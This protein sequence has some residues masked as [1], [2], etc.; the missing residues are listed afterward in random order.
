MYR[1]EGVINIRV[2]KLSYRTDRAKRHR[3]ARE[4][5]YARCVIVVS[6]SISIHGNNGRNTREGDRESV[7]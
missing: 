5:L 2:T 6:I 1:N 3:V 4:R 7:A